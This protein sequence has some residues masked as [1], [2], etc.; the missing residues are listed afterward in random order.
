MEAWK[1]LFVPTPVL[2]ALKSEN[3]VAPTSIQ[4]LS[5]PHAIRDRLDILGAAETGSGKTL[6]FSIPILHHV[7]QHQET[8]NSSKNNNIDDNGDNSQGQDNDENTSNDNSDNYDKSDNEVE[9]VD[10]NELMMEMSDVPDDDDDDDDDDNDSGVEDDEV[11]DS[12]PEEV[13]EEFMHNIVLDPKS[14][15]V[16]TDKPLIA[17]ILEPTRELAIQVKNHIQKAAKYINVQIATVVGGMAPQKQRRILSHCPE[18]IIATPGR[19]WELLQEVNPHLIKIPTVKVL[20]VDEADR[21][22]EKGHFEE[23]SKLFEFMKENVES[24]LKRQT[25]VFSATLTMIHQ[26]PNRRLKK[27]KKKVDPEDKL[28]LLMQHI[29]VK[30]KKKVI[31]LTNKTG[32]AGGL[33]EARINC[34]KDE[35]HMMMMMMSRSFCFYSYV[36]FYLKQKMCFAILKMIFIVLSLKFP[37]NSD[38]FLLASDVAARGLDIPNVQHVIHYQVPRTI[39]NY[40]HRSGRTARA[41]Q[42]GLSVM[43]ISQDDVQNYR[44]IIKNLNRDEELPVFPVEYQYIP[45]L[46]A[47]LRQALEID[48]LDHRF[49]KVKRQNDWFSKAAEEMEIDIEDEKLLVDLGDSEEQRRHGVK[50]EQLRSSLKQSLKQPLAPKTFSG[51]YPTK[52]GK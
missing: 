41:N 32:T 43:L 26:G 38:G 30:Q 29:G 6:A 2:W 31:D 40:V 18:I 36:K 20:V 45:L 25:L 8:I 42:E 37:G 10:L 23:L 14:T 9:S 11:Y 4:A 5:I 34:A 44:K 13:D 3:M 21:M 48:K 15:T 7:L 27:K 46:K 39:E 17:L 1:N 47:Q 22:V 19:L 51:K 12:P 49:T 28:G 35:K 16:K 33:T 52:M 24:R 50:L